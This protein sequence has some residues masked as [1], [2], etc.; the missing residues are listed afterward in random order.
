M[1][2][3]RLTVVIMADVTIPVPGIRS[4]P[5]ADLDFT[6]VDVETTGW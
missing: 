2:V 5:L 3:G 6:V 1:S 4:V